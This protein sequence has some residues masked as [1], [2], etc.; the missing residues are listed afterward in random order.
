[1][2]ILDRFSE[3]PLE[4]TRAG[5]VEPDAEMNPTAGQLDAVESAQNP[6]ASSCVF[7]QIEPS[8]Q[9]MLSFMKNYLTNQMEDLA[10]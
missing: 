3:V 8:D 9:A 4:L 6:N 2:S 10:P 7:V 1:M 5:I